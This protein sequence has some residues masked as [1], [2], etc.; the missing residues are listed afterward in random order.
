M[1]KLND[2]KEP[3]RISGVAREG[4]S[5]DTS[6]L[7]RLADLTRRILKVPKSEIAKSGNGHDPS[8]NPQVSP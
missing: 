1:R 4:H 7:A 2:A 6:S 8:G 3:S 5:S